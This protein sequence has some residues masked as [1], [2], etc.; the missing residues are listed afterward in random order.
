M[1]R[2]EKNTEKVSV[3][4]ESESI[5]KFSKSDNDLGRLL[6]YRNEKNFQFIRSPFNVNEHDPL[7]SVDQFRIVYDR[8]NIEQI[9]LR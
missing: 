1:F 7:N 5:Q 9:Q 8:E 3:F 4:I 2:V 6:Q